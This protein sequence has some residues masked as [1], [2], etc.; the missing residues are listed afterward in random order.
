MNKIPIFYYHSIAPQKDLLWYKSYLTYELEYFEDFLKYLKLSNFQFLTLDEYFAFRNDPLCKRRKMICL[1]FDDGYLDNYV[2]VYPLLKKYN[3]KG[4]IFI[5]PDYVQQGGQIR[6]N[7]EDVWSGKILENELQTLGFLNWNEMMLM[8]QSGII[9][10]QSHTMTHTK[11]F[12]S[13]KIREFHNPNANYL[14]P[15]VNVFPETKSTYITNSAFKELIPYGTPFFEEGSAIINRKVTLNPKFQLECQL[16]LK[17]YDWNNYLFNECYAIIKSIYEEYKKNETLIVS[18]ETQLEYE[19]RVKW[20][21][22]QSK[23]IIEEK[24][25]K[26]VYHICWPHG[27][28]NEFCHQIAKEE[29]YMSSHIVLKRGEINMFEDRFDRTGSGVVKNNHNLTLWK[30]KYKLGSYR[31][32]WPYNWISFIYSKLANG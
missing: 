5:S 27:D 3:A 24:L 13:D 31:D 21:I 18:F 23:R 10:I 14:Y 17:N 32:I 30:A 16:L 22:G 19:V 29:G 4:T 28:Y 11:H 2:F 15:I 12:I 9:D 25:G 7:L 6:P 1:T 20:E 8:E 26:K